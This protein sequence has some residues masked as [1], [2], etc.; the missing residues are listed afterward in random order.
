MKAKIIASIRLGGA[1]DA[2]GHLGLS[3]MA[4]DGA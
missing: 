2:A 1:L 4:E 3:V